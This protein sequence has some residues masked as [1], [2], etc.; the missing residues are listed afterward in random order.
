MA[1]MG[2]RMMMQGGLLY[3]FSVERHV[4]AEHL[5]RSLDQYDSGQGMVH[6]FPHL[7]PGGSG[8]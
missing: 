5:L 4:P 2:G 7:R 3:E 8:V 1:M 6:L